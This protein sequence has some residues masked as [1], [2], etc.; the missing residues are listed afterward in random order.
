[1][2]LQLVGGSATPFF[3]LLVI[4][5][6]SS[7]GVALELGG[8]LLFDEILGRLRA[9]FPL[10]TQHQKPIRGKRRNCSSCAAAFLIK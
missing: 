10:Q 4:A 6:G 3:I 2:E 1:M 9:G 7:K 8:Q 5:S